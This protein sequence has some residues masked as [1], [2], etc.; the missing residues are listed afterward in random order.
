M[1][2][3][4]EPKII[5]FEERKI[6]GLKCTTTLKNNTIGKLW[7]DFLKIFTEIPNK[8]NERVCLGICLPMESSEYDD[9]TP[10]DYIAGSPVTSFADVPEGMIAHTISKGKYTS[11]IHKGS[12]ENL[13]ETYDYI[14]GEW[15][16]KSE[17]IYE[18]R[19]QLEW[20]DLLFKYGEQDS[21]LEILIPIK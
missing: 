20:Y 19:D 3:K 7:E 15:L 16:N 5:E 13:P 17:Y 9:Q 21:E 12:L 18:N 2:R 11:F 6:I 10:F 1:S 4:M 8:S 14:Y